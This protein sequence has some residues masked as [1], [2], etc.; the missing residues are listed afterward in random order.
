MIINK[1]NKENRGMA[2]KN[3]FSTQPSFQKTVSFHP[4]ATGGAS[5]G[6]FGKT[7]EPKSPTLGLFGAKSP[8]GN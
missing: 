6:M 7:N 3:L 8:S 4:S 5:G 1:L 2:Q